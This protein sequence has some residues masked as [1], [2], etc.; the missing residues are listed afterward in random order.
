VLELTKRLR[1]FLFVFFL[2]RLGYLYTSVMRSKQFQR[3]LTKQGLKFRLNTKVLSAEKKDGKVYL[4]AEP[5]KG[6][7]A[8]TVRSFIF[9]FS[10]QLPDVLYLL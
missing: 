2:F 4:Q 8:E 7:N 3:L 1:E 9:F 6:G 5:A 10:N